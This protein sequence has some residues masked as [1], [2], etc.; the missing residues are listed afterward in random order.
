MSL[1]QI[2]HFTALFEN[3]NN[4]FIEAVTEI[5]LVITGAAERYT[6]LVDF[7]H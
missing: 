5:S 2:K 4:T 6:I 3:I 7:K 1:L